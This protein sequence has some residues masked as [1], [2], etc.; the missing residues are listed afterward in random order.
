[1]VSTGKQYVLVRRGS[2]A[3]DGRARAREQIEMTEARSI[4]IV[5]D[6][7]RMG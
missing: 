2:G 3:Y 7:N 6:I 1:M 4:A 5:G